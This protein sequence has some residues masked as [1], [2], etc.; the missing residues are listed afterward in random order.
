[1][2]HLN[3]NDLERFLNNLPEGQ[4]YVYVEIGRYK[5]FMPATVNAAVKRGHRAVKKTYDGSVYFIY[6][7][8]KQ[9]V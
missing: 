9:G 4:E 5:P 7:K 1:M 6:P 8:N 3:I 2:A